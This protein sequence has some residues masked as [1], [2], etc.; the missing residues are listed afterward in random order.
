[1]RA[2]VLTSIAALLLA[3]AAAAEAPRSGWYRGLIGRTAPALDTPERY[4]KN[5]EVE[6]ELRVDAAGRVSGSY[7]YFDATTRERGAG[8]AIEGRVAPG[9]EAQLEEKVGSRLT[10][11][12]LG[13]L[14][15][16]S[17]AGTWTD[18][19][20]RKTLRF[21]LERLPDD[22]GEEFRVTPQVAYRARRV[23]GT[24]LRLPFL[25]RHPSREVMRRVNDRIDASF[26]GHRCDPTSSFPGWPDDH[27][28]TWEVGWASGDLL[29]VKVVE[30]RFC[31]AA[32][33]TTEDL[34]FTFDLTTGK[35]VSFAGLF[36]DYARDE[37]TILETLF[38]G[39]SAGLDEECRQALASWPGKDGGQ[40]ARRARGPVFASGSFRFHLTE[41]ALHVDET[42]VPHAIAACAAHAE[43][44]YAKLLRFVAPGSPI[45]RVAAAGETSP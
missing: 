2:A 26:Q 43:A 17:F 41:A 25:T 10:G 3:G 1:M 30:E 6:M 15:G 21:T 37:D 34:S 16:L 39:W 11:R 13:S 32:Y 38:A 44:P 45:A 33:P 12:W 23:V 7:F 9:G 40:E 35:E 42:D 8:I 4:Q 24:N 31:G 22:E 36:R 29:S 19:A 28:V 5:R 18:P 27:D 14:D 20:R